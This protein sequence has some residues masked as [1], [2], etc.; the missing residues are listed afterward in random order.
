MTLLERMKSV[1]KVYDNYTWGKNGVFTSEGVEENSKHITYEY[2]ITKNE[3]FYLKKR[4]KGK[5]KE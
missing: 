2:N 3:I 5:K 4:K 1:S